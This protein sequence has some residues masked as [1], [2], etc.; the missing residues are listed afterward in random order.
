MENNIKIHMITFANKEPFMSSQQILNSTYKNCGISSHTMWNAQQIYST[1]FYEKNANIIE[2]YRTIGFGLYIWKPY[3]IY[4][5]LKTIE[6]DEFIYYQDSSRYDSTGLTDNIIPVCEYMNSKNIEL[7]PGFKVNKMNK[8]LIKNECLK[9]LKY[10]SNEKFLSSDHYHTSPMIFK[11]TPNTMKFIHE[12]L[13]LCQIPECIV[14][15]TPF[16]QC[17]QA[18][19]NI[20][21]D[22]YGYSGLIGTDDKELSKKYN[23]YWSML[24]K[25]IQENK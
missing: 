13:E 3:I 8:Y 21:L 25:Y 10:D 4:E 5:K 2:K 17:D 24:L 20:L 9:Y 16:H 19:L 22:K 12:W 18:I 1:K 6:F 11:K 23:L 14:K 7:L 15:N